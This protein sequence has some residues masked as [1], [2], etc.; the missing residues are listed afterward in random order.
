M[1]YIIYIIIGGFNLYLWLQIRS[2]KKKVEFNS[3]FLAAISPDSLNA[4]IELIK[5][6]ESN[7]KIKQYEWILI[8][9][10]HSLRISNLEKELK[11]VDERAL[12]AI[13]NVGSIIRHSKEFPVS[14]ETINKFIAEQGLLTDESP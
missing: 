13:N 1:Q 4:I 14:S 3:K 5:S 8:A 7:K 12:Q 6:F 10:E 9:N 11:Q 2:L